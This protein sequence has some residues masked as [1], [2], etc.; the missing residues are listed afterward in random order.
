M[1]D[2]LRY[3]ELK[4]GVASAHPLAVIGAVRS[5]LR[6]NGADAAEVARFSGEAFARREDEAG[7]REVCRSWVDLEVAPRA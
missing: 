6:R 3:P 7:L 5:A 1:E 4:V 2:M